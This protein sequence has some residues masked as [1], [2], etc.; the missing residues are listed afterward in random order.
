[1]DDWFDKLTYRF[2]L[3]LLCGVGVGIVYL[4]ATHE[5]RTEELINAGQFQLPQDY[6]PIPDYL[7][8]QQREFNER[9]AGFGRPPAGA[10]PAM[11]RVSAEHDDT[12]PPDDK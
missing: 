6:K 12:P 8:Q 9:V 1:M 5:R 11:R 7:G 10:G 4:R 2:G 3:L